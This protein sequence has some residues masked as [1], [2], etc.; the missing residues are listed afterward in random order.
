MT[1]LE[2]SDCLL[3]VEELFTLLRTRIDGPLDLDTFKIL[4]LFLDLIDDQSNCVIIFLGA[5][6][7]NSA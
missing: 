4:N 1:H 2:V 6:D 7:S 5:I 3:K